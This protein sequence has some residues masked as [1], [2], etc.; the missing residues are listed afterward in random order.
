HEDICTVYLL[1]SDD[2]EDDDCDWAIP[3]SLFSSVDKPSTPKS[4]TSSIKCTLR[5]KS[6][7]ITADPDLEPYYVGLA[8][9]PGAGDMSEIQMRNPELPTIKITVGEKGGLTVRG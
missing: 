1:H 6:P 8:E 3:G 7:E 5:G 9:E 4:Q 2:E